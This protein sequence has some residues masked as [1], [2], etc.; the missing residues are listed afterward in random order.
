VEH[1]RTAERADEVAERLHEVLDRLAR[2][3]HA[4]GLTDEQA[5]VRMTTE[6]WETVRYALARGALHPPGLAALAAAADV[7]LGLPSDEPGLRRD[8]SRLYLALAHQAARSPVPE[9]AAVAETLL[10]RAYEVR[11]PAFR[12]HRDSPWLGKRLTD[13]LRTV[14]HTPSAKTARS[15]RT[16]HE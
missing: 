11:P 15:R 10:D 1:V 14:A 9:D 8:L 13:W 16:A 12:H 4:H 7:R 2:L 5:R 6:V 3:F